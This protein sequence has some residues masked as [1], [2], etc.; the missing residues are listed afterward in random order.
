[1]K[2]NYR[3]IALAYV[4]AHPGASGFLVW[5]ELKR[6]SRSAK[7]FGHRSMLADLFG[8]SFGTTY[9]ALMSLEREGAIWSTW[10][11]RGRGR[12]NHM[13]MLYYPTR[14]SA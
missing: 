10:R 14:S 12:G 7:W 5:M 6:H 11:P 9:V 4:R 3:E 1:M 13:S 2:P 8:P